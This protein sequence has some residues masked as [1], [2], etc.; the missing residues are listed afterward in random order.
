[1]PQEEKTPVGNGFDIWIGILIMASVVML[2]YMGI[3]RQK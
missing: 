2:V 1:M 3:K